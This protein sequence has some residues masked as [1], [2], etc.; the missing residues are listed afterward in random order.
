MHVAN[1]LPDG[2]RE[3]V[4]G[5]LRQ[6]HN[7]L[8]RNLGAGAVHLSDGFEESALRQ[9]AAHD[10]D[11]QRT[12]L[13]ARFHAKRESGGTL[14]PL[15]VKL[16]GEIGTGVREL[17]LARV[18]TCAIRRAQRDRHLVV[19]HGVLGQR[20]DRCKEDVDRGAI[21]RLSKLAAV[22]RRCSGRS[23]AHAE[24]DQRPFRKRQFMVRL[25]LRCFKL[26]LGLF[27]TMVGARD[28]FGRCGNDELAEIRQRRR[29]RRRRRRRP[30]RRLGNNGFRDEVT[31][32]ARTLAHRGGS[33]LER[34]DRMLDRVG[35]RRRTH[36]RTHW[37]CGRARGFDEIHLIGKLAN[38][39][40][41][42]FQIT[43]DGRRAASSGRRT[44]SR[45][46]GARAERPLVA[47]QLGAARGRTLVAR[48]FDSR[49]RET[50]RGQIV[51]CVVQRCFGGLLFRRWHSAAKWRHGQTAMHGRGDRRRSDICICGGA[52][53]GRTQRR[54]A[55]D[56]GRSFRGIG[57]GRGR[58]EFRLARFAACAGRG[59]KFHPAKRGWALRFSALKACARQLGFQFRDLR[60]FLHL[61]VD[62]HEQH[63][64]ANT[65]ADRGAQRQTELRVKH[66]RDRSGNDHD[67]QK[68]E[69]V[70]QP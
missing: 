66:R 48:G 56:S 9:R 32:T 59:R 21:D 18:E 61:L 2:R 70:S 1:G 4:D 44:R 47:D 33:G 55:C 11:K 50:H 57:S 34:T 36:L 43:F 37:F 68:H 39:A 62:Q 58:G 65:R 40:L 3:R 38:L 51:R 29:F 7:E 31:E 53:R 64:G 16:S 26:G 19:V 13:V 20:H 8:R 15:T 46:F 42:E 54:G 25:M 63:P 45:G 60:R 28:T 14:K 12:I 27:R 23:V 52:L 24:V 41:H 5:A 35:R 67:A 49:C 69:A 10:F 6:K 30:R 17:F 22:R